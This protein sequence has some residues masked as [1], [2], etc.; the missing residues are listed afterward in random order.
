MNWKEYAPYLVPLLVVALLARR[1][2]K[3]Q[4]PSAVRPGRLWILPAI[5][6]LMTGLTLA[7]GSAPSLPTVGAFILAAAAGGTLG[8]FRVHTLEFSIDPETKAISSKS[9]PFG[10]FLLVGLLVFRYAIRYLVNGEGIR[11]VELVRWTDGALIFTVAMIAAQSVHT[12]VRASRL[13]PSPPLPV[14]TD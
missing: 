2:M 13:A 6:L 5:L 12:W 1:A 3:A 7:N 4:R 9:T 10:A 8:W 14:S 11:G